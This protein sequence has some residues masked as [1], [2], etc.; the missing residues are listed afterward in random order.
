MYV[1]F[2]RV[3]DA[4]AL[5]ASRAEPAM[6][7]TATATLRFDSGLLATLTCLYAA[8]YVNRFVI[9]GSAA[10]IAVEAAAA[11]TDTVR[12]VLSVTRPDGAEERFPCRSSI[13]WHCSCDALRRP[14]AGKGR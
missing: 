11:E 7:D 3:A 2:G 5:F 1:P 6:Q 8:P 10:R 14:V 4:R 13:H 12:P 9:H